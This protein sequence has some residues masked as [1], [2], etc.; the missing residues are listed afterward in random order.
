MDNDPA[1]LANLS[2]EFPPNNSANDLEMMLRKSTS[3]ATNRSALQRSGSVDKD[4]QL[5]SLDQIQDRE[6][7]SLQ[8]PADAKRSEPQE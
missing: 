1:A 6:L 4:K 5:P 3:F 8:K 7:P 2:K